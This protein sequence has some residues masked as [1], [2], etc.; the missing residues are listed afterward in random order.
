[1]YL[2]RAPDYTNYKSFQDTGDIGF[3]DVAYAGFRTNIYEDMAGSRSMNIA[4]EMEKETQLA[5]RLAPEIFEQQPAQQ[6]THLDA[7][8]ASPW[9][10][11]VEPN[12][13][14]L[15]KRFPEESFRGR[16]EIDTDIADYASQLRTN[17]NEVNK[18]ASEWESFFGTLGG[19]LA[20]GFSDPLNILT[21]PVG[22]GRAT[23]STFLRSTLNAFGRG[24]VV[25]AG[26]ETM[27]QPFVYDYKKDIDSPYELSDAV[28][29]IA[30]GGIGEGLLAGLG[31]AVSRG[32]HTLR[33]KYEFTPQQEKILEAISQME[34]VREETGAQTLAEL[35]AQMMIINDLQKDILEGR[36]L[37]LRDLDNRIYSAIE[38]NQKAQLEQ[39][40][41]LTNELE[42]EREAL[43]AQFDKVALEA[44]R[45]LQELA[46]KRMSRSS[47]KQ[48][49]SKQGAS[50]SELAPQTELEKIYDAQLAEWEKLEAE[51]NL[52]LAKK[53][54]S[55]EKELKVLRKQQGNQIELEDRIAK[56]DQQI[57]EQ[58]K[59]TASL[60]AEIEESTKAK[61]KIAP[62]DTP[63][64]VKIKG[65]VSEILNAI[66]GG[67]LK[68]HVH[69]SASSM[70]P[71]S[72][73]FSRVPD[74][75]EVV[76]IEPL[77]LEGQIKE[78]RKT[79]RDWAREKIAG[80]SVKT[81]DGKEVLISMSGIKHTINNAQD[82]LLATIP[83]TEQILE[84]GR[85]IGS[86]PDRKFKDRL[87]H[88]Y[89][90]KGK[91][92]E[93]TLD[94]IAVVKEDGKGHLYYDHSIE[95]GSEADNPASR[96]GTNLAPAPEGANQNS[97]GLVEN[98]QLEAMIDPE[99][100]ELHINAEAFGED[101]KHL[102]AVLRE[103]VIGH[104]GIRQVLGNKFNDVMSDIRRSAYNNPELR[105]A[106]IEVSG[107]DP[108]TRQ[109]INPEA[110]YAGLADHVI[111]DEIISKMARNEIPAS[112]YTW[113][114][115]K[116]AF[117][118]AMRLIGLV[119]GDISIS[120]MKSIIIKSQKSLYAN[121]GRSTP[122]VQSNSV[123][124]IS[125]SSQSV[126]TE[127]I[128]KLLDSEAKDVLENTDDGLEI[129]DSNGNLVSY[130]RSLG[131]SERTLAALKEIE[132][133]AL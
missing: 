74:D 112:E 33:G 45:E 49:K 126:S 47:K 77:R 93:E 96:A 8:S 132:G 68:V 64:V 89:A 63:H 83:H 37:D 129:F 110:P 97:I 71:E 123:S 95:R 66:G 104:Y 51:E 26:F 98:G 18:H 84:Q 119:D 100:G 76:D 5:F 30:F 28:M 38:S 92:N 62:E 127:D 106:W 3:S 35:Q 12:L 120:E 65:A 114:R 86:A 82:K 44:Q 46:S 73:M 6:E 34:Q 2:Y 36:P 32:Y 57:N 94:I 9:E 130:K 121:A 17:F 24:A 103:E 48:A 7:M 50:E 29:N 16:N 90:V 128:S 78:K 15:R 102:L 75:A 11:Y 14:V 124:D 80:K 43:K 40:T 42:L 91:L 81:T 27:A 109:I 133:C 118:K 61:L 115:I 56:L 101:G 125:P 23:G 113:T 60:I 108:R 105:Q 88:Y 53:S 20:A 70:T 55:A 22:V 72:S 31:H 54:K 19:G 117:V 58:K 67:H 99:T 1:M 25:G 122:K 87:V 107:S 85:F 69:Q 4:R 131:E 79:L 59:I 10:L 116:A 52:V 111:A 39:S 41:S 13:D 21:L